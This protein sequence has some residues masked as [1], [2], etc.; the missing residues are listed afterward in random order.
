MSLTLFIYK[1]ECTHVSH[2]VLEERVSGG[3]TAPHLQQGPPRPAPRRVWTLAAPGPRR[4]PVG[5]VHLDRVAPGVLRDGPLLSRCSRQLQSLLGPCE[6]QSSNPCRIHHSMTMCTF[7]KRPHVHGQREP[8]FLELLEIPSHTKHPLARR[9]LYQSAV[10]G[11]MLVYNASSPQSYSN[12]YAWLHEFNQHQSSHLHH[13]GDP[14]EEALRPFQ[15]AEKGYPPILVIGTHA[16]SSS[17][18][19]DVK[20]NGRLRCPIA[21]ETDGFSITVNLSSPSRGSVMR[22]PQ[23]QDILE[24]YWHKVFTSASITQSRFSQN[25]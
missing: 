6:S 10:H 4:Q 20:F 18:T 16:H 11:I 19:D 1:S 2:V 21:E 5:Q 14:R 13:N 22:D 12:L 23:V 7:K 24:A 15:G 8:V 25:Y 17:R 3:R 9:C